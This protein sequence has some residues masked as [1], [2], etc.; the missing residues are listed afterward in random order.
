M[1]AVSKKQQK[2]MGICAHQPGK[3]RGKCPSHKVA[4]EFSHNPNHPIPEYAHAMKRKHKPKF[5]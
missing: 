1:P 4:E 5:H 2:F 3:A